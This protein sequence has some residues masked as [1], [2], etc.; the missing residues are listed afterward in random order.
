MIINE[1]KS[2]I[3]D[4]DGTLVDSSESILESIQS[5]FLMCDL[6]PMMAL[7]SDII[8]PPLMETLIKL[9]GVSDK[10]VLNQLAEKF[11]KNYDTFGFK[12]TK[13]F[14]GINEMLNELNDNG[15]QLY[16]ATNKR[17]IPTKKII[18]YLGWDRLFKEIY[19]LDSFSPIALS[20]KDI[21]AKIIYNHSLLRKDVIY[22][23]DLE[24]D[25]ISAQA[26]NIRYIMVKWGYEKKEISED[27]INIS[28]PKELSIKLLK[29]KKMTTK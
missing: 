13:V 19:S 5:A 20:K 24:D 23:G 28:S 29:A 1:F 9:S 10:D 11:K 6:K 21:L 8:G 4:L 17:D 3:F 27:T 12:K 7:N 18:N 22:V 14:D 26:N 2:I 25:R 15:F 16:I